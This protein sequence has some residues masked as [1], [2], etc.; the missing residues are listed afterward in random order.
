MKKYALLIIAFI[1]YCQVVTLDNG[2]AEEA[3]IATLNGV[4]IDVAGNPVQYAEIFVYDSKDIRRPAD[5]ISPKTDA[6]GRYQV[7]VKPGNYWAVARV[8]KGEKYG[9]LKPGDKHS[10]EPLAFEIENNET[11]AEDF[12]V[13]N[14]KESSQLIHKTRE[15]FF[16]IQGT[17]IDHQGKPLKSS[18]VYANNINNKRGIPDYISPWCD[19][20]GKFTLFVP[21]GKFFVG[22]HTEFPP[23]DTNKFQLELN[24]DNHLQDVIITSKE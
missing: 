3:Q 16:K 19:D 9:P 6:T 14:L 22:Y 10:G 13:V 7:I 20:Q 2:H 12:T 23:D 21:A 15:G 8:R 11:L 1:V 24:I 4:V 5:Y 17:V 18:Y